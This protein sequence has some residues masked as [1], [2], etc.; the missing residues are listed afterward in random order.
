VPE[1]VTDD[2]MMDTLK[3]AF[4]FER[5]SIVLFGKPVLQP[6][7]ISWAGD[8]P[9][10]YSGDT[11]EPRPWPGPAVNLLAMVNATLADVA[12]SAPAFNHVLLNLYRD[13]SDSMGLHSDDESELGG[14]P[15][16]ASLSFGAARCFQIVPKRK[17]RTK[18]APAEKL[19][20]S[21]PSGSL[22]LMEPPMQ[23]YYLH[24]LQKTTR[25][26]GPRLN[27][28]FRSIRAA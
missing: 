28:T 25:P 1:Y 12:P 26:V 9:Y 11:L 22:L 3:A 14:D 7:L 18:G 17:Y 21:L 6:R 23:R 10:A 5:R 20:I 27:L 8:Q 24:G 19:N 15:F 16:I 2:L 13:G 4:D